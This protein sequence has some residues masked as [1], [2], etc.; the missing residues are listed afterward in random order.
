MDEF[1]FYQSIWIL[2]EK[3]L[4]LVSFFGNYIYILNNKIIE[5]VIHIYIDVIINEIKIINDTIIIVT[6]D[7][8]IFGFNNNLQLSRK[9]DMYDIVEII[10]LGN[11][12]FITRNLVNT[13][14]IWN[15]RLDNIKRIDI[16]DIIQWKL[17]ENNLIIF[18]SRDILIINLK[19]YSTKKYFN[20]GNNYKI[21]AIDQY[22]GNSLI[23]GKLNHLK[24]KTSYVIYDFTDTFKIIEL[25]SIKNNVHSIT[26]CLNNKAFCII[27]ED[28]TKCNTYTNTMRLWFPEENKILFKK[29]DFLNN[30]TTYKRSVHSYN[31]GS[32]LLLL[33]N[34]I[35]TNNI[36]SINMNI[37][38]VWNISNHKYFPIHI[39]EE[40]KM[41]FLIFNKK[42]KLNTITIYG[43][44][45]NIIKFLL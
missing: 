5:L 32:N 43:L 11:N 16:D 13:L 37:L 24:R 30:P 12:M 6:N 17:L 41:L 21:Q 42:T 7:G 38:P 39:K 31:D 26:R 29:C 15:T 33:N 28:Y 2:D 35:F 10:D 27:G 36:V 4:A 1:P 34:D 40:V 3:K 14:N 45:E 44:I 23:I 22:I 8:Y 18:S 25:F 19:T 20:I 9:V